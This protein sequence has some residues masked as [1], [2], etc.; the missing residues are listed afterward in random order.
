[1]TDKWCLAP[2][3][4]THHVIHPLLIA[5]STHPYQLTGL[6]RMW[7]KLYIYI[8]NSFYK[9]ISWSLPATMD[10]GWVP[11]KPIDDK[12][13]LVQVI[14]WFHQETS[15]YLNQCWPWSMS[16]YSAT[17]FISITTWL[18][19]YL[20]SHYINQCWLSV[21]WTNKNKLQSNFTI[22][23]PVKKKPL[24]CRILT[25]FRHQYVNSNGIFHF[26]P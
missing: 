25:I 3:A 4:Y 15:H 2:Y 16:P 23:I 6:W 1:M 14:V 17:R 21:K 22:Q 10:L 24:K 18:V 13:L 11:Q 20:M 5:A 7:K 12:Y 26:Q 8:S 19:T 9:L